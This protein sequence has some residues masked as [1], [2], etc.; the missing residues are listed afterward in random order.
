[1]KTSRTVALTII[2]NAVICTF[3]VTNHAASSQ[4]ELA[5]KFSGMQN[6]HLMRVI[7]EDRIKNAALA[8]AWLY[9]RGW[10]EREALP[11]AFD[12]RAVRATKL[13]DAGKWKEA[14]EVMQAQAP[15]RRVAK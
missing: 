1:M 14:R 10:L 15:H 3:L 5:D 4:R 11:D 7:D 12:R 2:A 13:M 8:G 6:A 9:E